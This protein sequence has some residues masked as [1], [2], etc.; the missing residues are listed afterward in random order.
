[1]SG[2][3]SSNT[4]T[5][6]HRVFPSGT[7]QRGGGVFPTRLISNRR[8][9]TPLRLWNNNTGHSQLGI[10]NYVAKEHLGGHFGVKK[11]PCWWIM[12]Q[13][14]WEAGKLPLRNLPIMAGC[15]RLVGLGVVELR[16][17]HVWENPL[18]M[19]GLDANIPIDM[20]LENKNKNTYI[21]TYINNFKNNNIYIYFLYNNI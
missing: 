3:R 11:K 10:E 8:G 20:C 4:H 15:K 13:V 21:N 7:A 18:K 16:W 1:M 12:L 9:D 5:H 2:Q 6:A 19:V 17:L 14:S